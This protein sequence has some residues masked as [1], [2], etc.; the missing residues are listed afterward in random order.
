MKLKKMSVKFFYIMFSISFIGFDISYP[1]FSNDS[2]P[3]WSS[4]SARG[5]IGSA[6]GLNE[7]RRKSIGS[8]TKKECKSQKANS[9]LIGS[10]LGGAM[11]ERFAKNRKILGAASG[12]ALGAL[13][14]GS[15]IDCE[16]E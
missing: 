14:G 4:V 15:S 6:P 8:I 13:V 2:P 9:R 5:A 1:V 11:G 10:V 16:T 3:I 7:L 12:A